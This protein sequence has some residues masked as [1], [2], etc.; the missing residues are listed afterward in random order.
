MIRRILN[1]FL[2]L[3]GAGF[4]L[5]SLWLLSATTQNSGDFGRLHVWLLLL[6]VG[7]A[8]VLLTLIGF[9]LWHLVRQYRERV[10][11]ARLTARLVAMFVGL[12]IAPVLLVYY[13][14]F[15]FLSR[16][17]D[18]WFDV[19][20]EQALD[21]SLELSRSALDTRTRELLTRTERAAQT[22]SDSPNLVRL[23]LERAREE[24]GASE[25]A[26]F[27]TSGRVLAVSALPGAPVVPDHPGEDI[28]LQARQGR[29]YVGLD[30]VGSGLYVRA[31]VPFEAGELLRETQLL[32][33]L[34]P[35][36]DKQSNLAESVQRE[37]IRYQEL[38]VLRQPLK[39]TFVLTL[40]L[41]LLVSLLTAVWGAFFAAR[42][43]VAPI[44]DLAEG[45][46]AVARGDFDTRLPVQTRDEVGFL[47]LSFNEMTSRLADAREET[48]RTQHQVESERAYLEAVL[49]RLS[50]GVIALDAERRVR[51][52]NGAA[53][54]MLGL[55]VA[56][57]VGRPFPRLRGAGDAAREFVDAVENRLA[58]GER[59]WR[60][61]IV[62]RAATG[63]R[64]LVCSCTLLP[65]DADHPG[66][67]VLVF[68]EVTQLIQAQRDAAW[69]EVA[70]RLAHEIKNPLTPIQLAAERLRHK[71]LER[72][73]PADAEMLERSTR[74][75][76]QQV[77]AMQAM[78]NAFS[79]YA[80]APEME[81]SKFSLNGLVAEVVDLYRERD[82][83]TGIRL[84]L[85][86][87]LPQVEADAG[88][89]RQMLHNLIKNALEALEGRTRPE[90]AVTT[91]LRKDGAVQI[92]E[93]VVED[94][95]PGFAED[96]LARPFEPYVT[97]KP[98]GTGLGLAIV[99]KLAEEHGGSLSADNRPE[100]G[101]RIQIR[102][103]LNDDAHAAFLARALRRRR[104]E[105]RNIA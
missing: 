77:E 31:V 42:R 97:S 33:A 32:Q 73:A 102:L 22:L 68:D 7:G 101:A 53:A 52:A 9:N 13:F 20:V 25:M 66:G 67:T 84:D 79:E 60:E 74:T 47:V 92:A 58:A 23:N 15:Q 51:T 93:I 14:S 41:V 1:T 10:P 2:F 64:I 54:S 76:V 89:I 80:R 35:V 18:S 98:K 65:G 70:R 61:E 96:I 87:A 44:R 29:S 43:V 86:A 28:M 16:G 103:P 91:R 45:T 95:G 56:R 3:M 55:D 71:F 100:G 4:I 104:D 94:N 6:N 90:V 19:R 105:R 11:G 37:F 62:L 34:Y 27:T 36:A 40:S 83:G 75:I 85:D 49:T 72:L 81:V 24:T 63:R 12:A 69:G 59:E 57:A 78:V 82:S 50:S 21:N 5:G 30:P 46:R 88:R 8:L 38:T 39:Y 17:I 26:I 48:Q 99:K